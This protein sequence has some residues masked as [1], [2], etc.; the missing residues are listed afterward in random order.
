MIPNTLQELT[1]QLALCVQMAESAGNECLILE[2]WAVKSLLEG[3]FLRPA[4]ME[5]TAE[6]KRFDDT[7]DLSNAQIEAMLMRD[8]GE[9]PTKNCK[10]VK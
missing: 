3:E 2:T 8:R 6:D 1:E 4:D 10:P 7:G 9:I 5:P